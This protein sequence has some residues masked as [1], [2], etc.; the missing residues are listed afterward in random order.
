PRSLTAE[1]PSGVLH[2]KAVV[3]D[4]EIALVTSANL[5]E[6]AFDRNI[7]AGVLSR[8]RALAASLARHFRVLIE[9]ELLLPLPGG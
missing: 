5:T 9:R 8:D 6:A 4:E 2:A 1:G 7:E 3:A